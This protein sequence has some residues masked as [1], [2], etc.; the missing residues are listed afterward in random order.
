MSGQSSGQVDVMSGK[1]VQGFEPEPFLMGH[2][3]DRERPSQ[4][5]KT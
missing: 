4:I 3:V 1:C 2:P 5:L